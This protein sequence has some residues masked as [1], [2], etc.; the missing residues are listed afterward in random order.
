MSTPG[1]FHA[2]TTKPF[3]LNPGEEKDIPLRDIDGGDV[4][5]LFALARGWTAI[6]PQVSDVTFVTSTGTPLTDAQ[7]PKEIAVWLVRHPDGKPEDNTQRDRRT[8]KAG[9][10]T[11]AMSSGGQEFIDQT[12]GLVSFRMSSDATQPFR[13]GKVVIKAPNDRAQLIQALGGHSDHSDGTIR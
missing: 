1:N 12:D 5:T 3:Y 10:K 13:I 9:A 4:E 7:K 6:N 2:E 8:I 11:W